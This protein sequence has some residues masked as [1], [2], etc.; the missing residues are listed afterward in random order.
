MVESSFIHS[1]SSCLVC[2]F[3]VDEQLVLCCCDRIT[4]LL[5]LA[6]VFSRWARAA[7][8]D[9]FGFPASS[10]LRRHLLPTHDLDINT[11]DIRLRFEKLAS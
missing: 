2:I 11:F 7:F 9:T 4:D 6:P 8:R 1:T 5:L 10:R 3:V